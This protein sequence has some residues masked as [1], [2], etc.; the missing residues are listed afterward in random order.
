MYKHGNDELFSKLA[1]FP[2]VFTYMPFGFYKASSQQ[3]LPC[4]K[5]LR[6]NINHRLPFRCMSFVKH[7]YK[8]SSF[9]TQYLVRG[10]RITLERHIIFLHFSL[11]TYEKQTA[12]IISNTWS[13]HFDCISSVRQKGESQNG[14]FKKT[15][16]A[17][18]RE[19]W[20]S[21]FSWNIRFE[22]HP[23]VLLLTI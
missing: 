22:I 20:C 9:D 3:H 23:F 16:Q 21:S 8:H 2:D 4:T 1:K 6:V 5:S 18:F 19:I 13:C 17:I 14:C 12:C 15:K 7:K 10:L 11:F